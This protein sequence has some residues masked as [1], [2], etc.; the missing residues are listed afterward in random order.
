[1]STL[2]NSAQKV[3]DTLRASG[4]QDVVTELPDSTRTAPE[5]AQAIGCHV[6]QIVKSLVFRT[7]KSRQPILVL[8]SGS[9]R[10]EEKKLE[11]LIKEP[12]GKAD[13]NFV[14]QVTGFSIG[15]VPPVGHENQIST[16]MDED[17]LAYETVWAAAGTPH[18]VF[19]IAPSTLAQIT[20]AQVCNLKTDEGNDF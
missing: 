4:I 19:P 18:A 20:N 11:L 15:G 5:A 16:Y 6:G 9:N 1:M 8:A 12:L 13:A 10:V 17:L 3:R 14:K 7:K 2:S